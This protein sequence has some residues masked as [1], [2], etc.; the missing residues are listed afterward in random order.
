MK[1]LPKSLLIIELLAAL[2][3]PVR[4]RLCRLLESQELIVGEVARVVQL[5]QSTVSR[6]LKVLT[7]AGLLVKRAEGTATLYRLVLDE[8]S[9]GVRAIWIAV[10]DQLH[11][12]A[13]FEEDS[14]RL[15]SVL[16]ERRTDSLSYFG[17]VA[18]EWDSVRSEMFGR[19]FT[20]A[21]LLGLLPREWRV[22]DVGCGTGNAAELLAPHVREVL[23]IDQ[24]GPMLDAAKKRLAKH[25]NVRFEQGPVESLPLEDESVDAAVCLL[26]LHHVADPAGAVKELARVVRK[27][28]VVLVVDMFEHDRPEFRRTMGH[29]HM[30]FSEAAI[31]SHFR[32]AGLG[33][34]SISKLQSDPN[35]KGPSL[36]LAMGRKKKD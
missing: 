34:R 35:S 8:L 31:D 17:R 23:A 15:E 32:G 4:L 16:A 24:S 33:G 6:H 7:D 25:K 22:A 28:G 36:F 9:P 27:N 1:N 12:R 19:D 2:G 10:R 14:R 29:Q 3:E 21:A 30:G 13:Q 5:P 18:G 20:A 11:D 26:V